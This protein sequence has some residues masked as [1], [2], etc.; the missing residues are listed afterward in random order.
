MHR[1]GDIGRYSEMHGR[2]GRGGA[3][4][5][6]ARALAEESGA[7]TGGAALRLGPVHLVR[8]RVRIRVRVRVS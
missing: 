5:R 4:P 8:V 6:R 2:Y 3:A 1:G 7:Q